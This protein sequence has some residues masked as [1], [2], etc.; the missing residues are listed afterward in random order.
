MSGIGKFR[1][2]IRFQFN[3]A[4]PRRTAS[5]ELCCDCG[6]DTQ[7]IHEW[8][9]VHYDVWLAAA[10]NAWL[11]PDSY[12]M[13]LCVGCIEGRLGR[14]LTGDDFTSAPI[15][16]M[17]TPRSP[18]LQLRMAVVCKALEAII[19]AQDPTEGAS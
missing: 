17:D 12:G 1:D 3:I 18:R 2:R 9:M 4:S 6:V 19:P 7:A 5:A 16:T 15:N 14:S 10:G 13:F 8:Y 11:T